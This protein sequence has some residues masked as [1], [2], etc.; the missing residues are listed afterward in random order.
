MKKPIIMIV[1]ARSGSFIQ[2]FISR[3]SDN[4]KQKP[5][6]N[7]SRDKKRSHFIRPK[8]INYL[9]LL[10]RQRTNRGRIAHREPRR[11]RREPQ[12]IYEE[13]IR[14]QRVTNDIERKTLWL[15]V[16]NLLFNRVPMLLL[17]GEK[18]NSEL[19]ACR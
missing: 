9:L 14:P 6:I 17:F 11:R 16:A 5:L 13:K 19:P 3:E 18:E 2:S 12:R 4:R 8:C 15:Y 1:E 10:Q 7:A